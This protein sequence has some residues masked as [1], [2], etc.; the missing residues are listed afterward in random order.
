MPGHRQIRAIDLQHEAGSNDRR[1]FFAHRVGDRGDIAL[2]RGVV[3]V[4]QEARD[5]AGRCGIEEGTDG[6]GGV[7]CPPHVRQ[8]LFERTSAAVTYRPDAGDALEA[9][10]SSEQGHLA[11]QVWETA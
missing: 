8:V 2:V 4:R 11:L 9:S 3:L 7:C 5:H 6:M 10:L 1:V